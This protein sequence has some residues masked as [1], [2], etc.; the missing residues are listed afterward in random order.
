[1][2]YTTFMNNSALL[3]DILIE[4]LLHFDRESPL[5]S[6]LSKA[7]P[8]KDQGAIESLENFAD[9]I[10]SQL[11]RL[12]PLQNDNDRLTKEVDELT[13]EVQMLL[14]IVDTHVDN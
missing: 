4:R 10:V 3:S 6:E 2:L 13:V 12:Q 8:A 1:M 14:D 5:A 11:G 9:I 7:L